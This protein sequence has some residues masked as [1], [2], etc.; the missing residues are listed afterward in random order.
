MI[1][2]LRPYHGI[3]LYRLLIRINPNTIG[4]GIGVFLRLSFSISPPLPYVGEWGEDEVNRIAF[5]I[6]LC[7]ET[8]CHHR[9]GNPPDRHRL[10]ADIHPQVFLY[11]AIIVV[12]L[13]IPDHIHTIYH[14]TTKVSIR[15]VIGWLLVI[16]DLTTSQI[17]LLVIRMVLTLHPLLFHR[18]ADGQLITLLPSA[19][20]LEIF[21]RLYT[22]QNLAIEYD[23]WSFTPRRNTK[24]QFLGCAFLDG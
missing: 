12:Q 17:M 23:A 3:Y 2:S 15:N 13:R 6:T 9:W 8:C 10:L 21:S 20:H 24:V 11:I 19:V 14:R 1:E 4:E 22:L 5:V 7:L 16:H 18:E